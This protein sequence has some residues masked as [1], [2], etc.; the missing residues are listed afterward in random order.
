IGGAIMAALWNSNAF[1]Q[2]LADKLFLFTTGVY[3]LAILLGLPSLIVG[4]GFMATGRWS[5]GA[6]RLLPF[7][8][9]VAVAFGFM[10][11]SHSLIPCSFDTGLTLP[12]WSPH[13]LPTS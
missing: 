6:K 3:L 5:Q 13:N 8:G 4:L 11:L 12:V 9:P 7:I 1:V 2:S 10:L